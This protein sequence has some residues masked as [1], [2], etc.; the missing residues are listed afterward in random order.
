VK[1]EGNKEYHVGRTCWR[2]LVEFRV[3][4]PV[5]FWATGKAQDFRSV[6]ER[7]LLAVLLLAG[8]RPVSVETLIDRI[9]GEAPPSEVRPSLQTDV[10]RLRRMFKDTD[11]AGKIR[12]INTSGAYALEV[13]PEYVDLFR[14]RGLREQ[15]RS[16]EHSGNLHQAAKLLREALSLWRSEPLTGLPGEWFDH[17]RTSL[18]GDY[19]AMAQ[20]LI[21]IELATSNH[22][23]I[24]GFLIDLNGRYPLDEIFTGQLMLAYYRCGRQV[25][26]I[27]L[28]RTTAR[29]LQEETGGE[30]QPRLRTL[31][32]NILRHDPSVASPRRSSTEATSGRD[33]RLPA[34]VA[35]FTGRATELTELSEDA[36][37]LGEVIVVE[38]MPGIGKTA[39]AVKLANELADDFPDACVHLH[40]HA[41]DPRRPAAPPAAALSELLQAVGVTAKRIPP[42]LAD[43]ARLWREVMKGRRALI[44]LDDA[45]DSRQVRPL[46][47][48]SPECRVIITSRRRLSGLDGARHYRLGVLPADDAAALFRRIA[49][50]EAAVN[51]AVRL[52]G[53]LPFAIRLAATRLRDAQVPSIGVLAAE[54]RGPHEDIADLQDPALAATFELSYR[55]LSPNQRRVF[56]RLGLSPATELTTPEVA[57]LADIPP[58]EA[59]RSLAEFLENYLVEEISPGRFQLHD[60]VRQYA[61]ARANREDS[62]VDRRRAAGRTLDFY[63]RKADLAD[64]T[65]YPYHARTGITSASGS[66]AGFDD[67]EAAGAWLTTERGNL[68]DLVQYAADHEFNSQAIDFAKSV[69][70]FFDSESQWEKAE[71]IQ[72]RALK[73][74]LNLDIPEAVAQIRLDLSV[75]Q[76]RTGQIHTA[77]ANAAEARDIS[78]RAR[79]AMREALALDQ[80][81]LVHWSSSDYREALA[82]FGEALDIHRDIGDSHGKA[83]CL[84]HLGMCLAQ[85]GRH[86]EALETFQRALDICQAIGDVRAEATTL[87]NFAH[88]FLALGYHHDAHDCLRKSWEIY[89]SLPGR[90]NKAILMNNFGDV[91]RYRFQLNSALKS[92]RE[93]LSEFSASHDRFNESNAL[94]N[95]GLT[96]SDM[97]K[98]NEALIHHKMA[99]S[100]AEEIESTGEKIRARLGIAKTDFGMG[101][102]SRATENYEDGRR[103]ARH[104]SDPYL[105]AQALNGLAQVT[106]LTK[107]HEAAR[108]FWRQAYD[109]FNHMGV[110]AEAEAV[111]LRLEIID[112][113]D[114]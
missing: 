62:A 39:L 1:E 114:S 36:D 56:R 93:A 24:I 105:E 43:R 76:W 15:A 17:M 54:L 38:G 55:D 41:H 10:Y 45:A 60:L 26:S 80:I 75:V 9:W 91:A 106:N 85:T 72:R 67:E 57:V 111:R 69:A 104:I 58:G 59:E 20:E 71:V 52:C 53:G 13:D 27:A 70:R 63:L 103:L 7:C 102:Y 28:Y 23:E 108:I 18:D 49:G 19:R 96:L 107:G 35:E 89:R 79:D 21:D 33:R 86:H 3:L 11:A 95:I 77:L 46:L 64:R 92:Y 25:D 4:G 65:I 99:M 2:V 31:Y 47:P 100:I 109:L 90:R 82:Y 87:S 8:G 5:E 44:L 113:A 74:G 88:T 97:E 78:H 51:D 112:L 83:E 22:T 50:P 94:N 12:L 34:P 110:V 73:I 42:D 66:T 29:L 81:G 98:Y 68:F 32:R 61:L 101:R 30:P 48:G 14:A 37:A 40:L 6:K 84:N 16:I